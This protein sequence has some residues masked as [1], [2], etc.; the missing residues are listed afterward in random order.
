MKSMWMFNT[1]KFKIIADFIWNM[2]YIKK[3][4]E[5]SHV[6]YIHNWNILIIPKHKEISRWTLNNIF[7]I[8]SLHSWNSKKEIESIFLEFYKK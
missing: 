5:G 6:K 2:W 7:K 1:I 3:S 8:I 4:Q